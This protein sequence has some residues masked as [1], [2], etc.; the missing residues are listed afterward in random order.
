M[1]SK[2]PDQ[3]YRQQFE[4]ITDV[5]KIKALL[6]RVQKSHALLSISIAD[7]GDYY[8]SVVIK[9]DGE[10]KRLEIDELH[11]V[12]GNKILQDTKKLNV[13]SEFQG[14]DISFQT[15]L[16][17]VGT[18]SEI[19][20]YVL[21]FPDHIKYFQRRSAYR[22]QVVR[23]LIIPVSLTC[24]NGEILQGELHNISAGGAC[25]R[26]SSALP[27]FLERGL[28]IP[29]CEISIP[30]ERPLTCALEVRHV[31]DAAPLI[32]IGTRFVNLNAISQ[33]TVEKFVVG[34]ERKLRRQAG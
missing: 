31:S 19:I 23:S 26:F 21:A 34:L 30:N 32:T 4:R 6:D 14:I 11:P 33:R 27:D 24:K 9:V 17:D 2:G 22:V 29:K 13:F 10:Q 25:I 5:T 1:A 7:H 8:N 18:Q 28:M 3:A 15:T 12:K 20:Y 16:V